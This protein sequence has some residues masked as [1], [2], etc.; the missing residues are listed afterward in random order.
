[1]RHRAALL[2]ELIGYRFQPLPQTLDLRRHA[3]QRDHDFGLRRA[4][5]LLHSVRGIQHSP[6]LHLVDFRV[7]EP[8]PASA[9]SQHGVA[10][11]HFR[12]RRQDC[13]TLLRG[14]VLPCRAEVRDLHHEVLV[15]RQELVQGRVQ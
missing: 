7:H 6:H 9:Q 3:D 15:S 8:D 10:L 12:D 14:G 2:L 1:M 13:L 5:L 4:A 11:A